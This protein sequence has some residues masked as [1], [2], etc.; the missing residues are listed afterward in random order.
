MRA[1]LTFYPRLTSG[2]KLL[3]MLPVITAALPSSALPSLHSPASTCPPR[4]ITLVTGHDNVRLFLPILFPQIPACVSSVRPGM[5]G[6]KS[7][8]GLYGEGSSNGPPQ[9]PLLGWGTKPYKITGKC[10]H[11]KTSKE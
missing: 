3:D 5:N 8:S 2:H 6:P 10:K 11:L 7:S 9:N 4:L 1:H